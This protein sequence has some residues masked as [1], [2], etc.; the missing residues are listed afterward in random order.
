MSAILH[1]RYDMYLFS[2]RDFFQN[3]VPSFLIFH[4]TTKV[5]KTRLHSVWHLY[6]LSALSSSSI[7][8]AR[9]VD[10]LLECNDS[11]PRLLP[12][13]SRNLTREI[14]MARWKPPKVQNACEWM[15]E[16]WEAPNWSHIERKETNEGGAVTFYV[17]RY[18]IGYSPVDCFALRKLRYMKLRR[19]DRSCSPEIAQF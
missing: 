1:R 19:Y 11:R 10:R 5:F 17:G 16:R 4:T 6:N 3:R 12:C 15:G 14:T 9:E 8:K 7:L 18:N 13:L 2:P